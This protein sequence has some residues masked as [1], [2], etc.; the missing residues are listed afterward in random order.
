MCVDEH[1]TVEA[2]WRREFFSPKQSTPG[3]AQEGMSRGVASSSSASL[4]AHVAGQSDA[5]TIGLSRL[6]S[7]DFLHCR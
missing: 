3:P 7:I 1:Q 5:T 2:E 4:M 6:R